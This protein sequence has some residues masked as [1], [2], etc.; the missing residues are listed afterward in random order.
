MNQTPI[1]QRLFCILSGLSGVTGVILLFLSFSFAQ[2]PRPGATGAELLAF[3]QQHY[4]AILWGAW[5][6]AVGPVFIVL[7]AFALVHLA[8]A[9][10]RLSGWMTL[11][12]ASILMTVSLVEITFYVGAL[13]PDPPQ[14]TSISL[15]IIDAI[16]HLYFIVAAPALF[17]P[18]GIVL[19]RSRIL[20]RVFS[21]VALG[22]A[23]AFAILG[24]AFLGNLT[25]PVAVTASAGVQAFWWLAA[26]VTLMARSGKLAQH[27]GAG[28]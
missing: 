23:A 21:Y 15:R 2:G 24:V 17:L 7:F 12:G 1:P 18:L 27:E 28:A 25:L 11:L 8:G 14:M 26:S 6:Q 10:S 16:Q 19:I 3:G 9:A 13:F 20:P 22:L 4:R 5:L